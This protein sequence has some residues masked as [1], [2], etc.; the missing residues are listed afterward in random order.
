[1]ERVTG[2]CCLVADSL[3]I[4]FQYKII[5]IIV[6][7]K[8][9]ECGQRPVPSRLDFIVFLFLV[10]RALTCFPFDFSIGTSPL[11]IFLLGMAIMA[12]KKRRRRNK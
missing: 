2:I 8:I 6:I 5:Q 10:A 11:V 1:M 9:S 7:V 3:W 4:E 12:L